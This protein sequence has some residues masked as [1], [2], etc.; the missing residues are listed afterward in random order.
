[1]VSHKQGQPLILCERDAEMIA[2][3]QIVWSATVKEKL[4]PVLY[5][6]VDIF[7][8]GQMEVTA[9]TQKVLELSKSKDRPIHQEEE[10]QNH[11]LTKWKKAK[12][13]LT[14]QRS[15]LW[16]PAEHKYWNKCVSIDNNQ[17]T[18]KKKVLLTKS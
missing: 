18:L 15:Q 17:P 12:P 11:I 5:S 1:M 13:K 3:T 6:K 2:H 9:E 14:R 7:D 8:E 10:N 16:T 4:S